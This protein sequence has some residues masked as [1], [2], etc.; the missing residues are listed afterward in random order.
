MSPTFKE[1]G[2]VITNAIAAEKEAAQR[3]R[4]R[5]IKQLND[6]QGDLAVAEG[7]IA[8]LTTAQETLGQ[9]PQIDAWV[10]SP[11]ASLTDFTKH[12]LQNIQSAPNAQTAS[13]LGVAVHSLVK[14]QEIFTAAGKNPNTKI[15][16]FPQE[17]RTDEEKFFDLAVKEHFKRTEKYPGGEKI[18]TIADRKSTVEK[19]EDQL[20]EMLIKAKGHFLPPEVIAEALDLSVYRVNQILDTLKK[21]FGYERFMQTKKSEADGDEY[22]I[23]LVLPKPTQESSPAAI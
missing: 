2:S 16:V 15:L 4:G 6:L 10:P 1:F 21:T 20:L 18:I 19:S 14:A 9:L 12:A 13:E 17:A 11:N 23:K 3:R 22:G 8:T 5:L 7:Q